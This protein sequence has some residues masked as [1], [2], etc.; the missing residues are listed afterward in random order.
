MQIVFMPYSEVAQMILKVK[1][2]ILD[3]ARE[4]VGKIKSLPCKHE[5]VRADR[6]DR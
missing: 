5:E 1:Y 2:K 6:K 4:M 3:T